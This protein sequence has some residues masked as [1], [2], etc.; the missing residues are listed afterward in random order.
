MFLVDGMK[1][2]HEKNWG[3]MIIQLVGIIVYFIWKEISNTRVPFIV[4]LF[5]VIILVFIPI[6]L[7]VILISNQIVAPYPTYIIN[8]LHF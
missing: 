1:S 3:S 6:S 4:N 7:I 2:S 8:I 5:N